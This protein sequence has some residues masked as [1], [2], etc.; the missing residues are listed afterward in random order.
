FLFCS[1]IQP[2]LNTVP[3]GDVL[4]LPPGYALSASGCG[5]YKSPVYPRTDVPVQHNPHTLDS[6]LSKAVQLRLPPD[7]PVATLFSGG[8]DS[9]LI[10]HY[11]RQHR[12]DAP[13]YFVGSADAPDYP[14]AA[15]YADRVGFDLRLVPFEAD[16][17]E[18][19]SLLEH[20]VE[21]TE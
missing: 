5:R 13:G 10:A 7:L 19:F 16:G 20:V 3:V 1:E 21:V 18:A 9:T 15:K 17:D 2:L 12:P 8:I 6:V 4:L 14:F 11:V